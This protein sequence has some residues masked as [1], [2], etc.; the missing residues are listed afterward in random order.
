VLRILDRF[1]RTGDGWVWAI[2]PLQL[3]WVNVHGLFALGIAVCA[4]HLVGELARPLGE[5]GAC[6]SWQR[7]RPLAAVTTLSV[8]VSAINPNG[9]DGA[10]YP[11]PQLAMVGTAEA[12]GLFGRIIIELQPSFGALSPLALVFLLSLVSLSL[13]SLALSWR[14]LPMSDPLLWIAFFYL[15]MGARRNV[16]LFAI[17]V[18]P[19]LVRNWNAWLDGR[20]LPVRLPRLAG[21]LISLVLA[22]LAL[23]AGRGRFLPRMSQLRAPGLGVDW[24]FYPTAAVDWIERESPP[25]P[26]AHSMLDGGFLIWRLY[27][28]YRVM[29]DGRLE[30][31][32]PERFRELLIDSTERFEAL[33][34]DYHFG[35]VVQRLVPGS[36]VEL[37]T[38]WFAH[39][40][41]RLVALD[42]TAALFVRGDPRQ[43]FPYPELDLDAPRLFP[44][45]EGSSPARDRLFLRRRTAFFSAAGRDDLA[46]ATWEEA[47]RRFPDMEQGERVHRMLLESLGR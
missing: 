45:L 38:H 47:L 12:R 17:V 33:D 37:L 18:A 25:G 2:V 16:P 6:P 34:A 15:V 4:M 41:W 32:G 29:V 20:E 22:A 10:L 42:H 14:T 8:L 31:F 30:I 3:L 11:L 39:P 9:L 36:G 46:L 19:M 24:P 40:E 13:V 35:V 5:A 43:A 21:V 1:E 28:D 23:D 27:P 7:V 26:I 44:P